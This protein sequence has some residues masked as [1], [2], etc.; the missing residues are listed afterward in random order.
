MARPGLMVWMKVARY[1]QGF[2][3]NILAF[4][5]K[6]SEKLP[7]SKSR[8][9]L[10]ILCLCVWLCLCVYLSGSSLGF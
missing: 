1:S 2:K 8:G 4:I 6:Y 5:I 9:R 10:C 3:K 7:D